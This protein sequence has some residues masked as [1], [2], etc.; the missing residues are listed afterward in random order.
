MLKYAQIC[1]NMLKYA[2]IIYLPN[3]N[4]KSII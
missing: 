1:S 3:I 2:Q 4:E